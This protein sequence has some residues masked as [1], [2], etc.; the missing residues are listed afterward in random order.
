MTATS[1]T[2]YRTRRT[3]RLVRPHWSRFWPWPPTW[4]RPDGPG[5]AQGRPSRD[6]LYALTTLPIGVQAGSVTA[7]RHPV[8][9]CVKVDRV[10]RF[11]NR[12]PGTL[13]QMDSR[14]HPG[15]DRRA[16][17]AHRRTRR[18]QLFRP[19][20]YRFHLVCLHTKA[21]RVWER[22]V[23]GIVAAVAALVSEW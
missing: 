8:C 5:T 7:E 16:G 19:C 2:R 3:G 11:V 13:V 22:M 20:K 10:F 23:L 9:L 15:I 1:D 12:T 6:H 18:R 17:S 14:T 4:R 21:N